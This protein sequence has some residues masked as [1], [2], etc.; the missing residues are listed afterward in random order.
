MARWEDMVTVGRVARTHGL[1]GHVIVDPLTDFVEERFAPGAVLEIET[2]GAVRPL[3]VA[4]SRLQVGRPVIS[5]EGLGRIE[6]VEALLGRELRVP[7]DALVPLEPGRYYRHDLVGCTVE[8]EDGRRIGDVTGV[9]G[10]TGGTHL[11]VRGD[12]GEVLIP[13]ARDVCPVIDVGARRIVVT[14][15]EGLL[16]AN[17]T[18][19]RTR[20]GRGGRRARQ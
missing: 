11:V 12:R 17:E 3:T 1:R 6:D 13:L 2:G 10:T 7:E 15:P 14:P 8:H 16:E 9:G 20:V 18:R 5:F 4:S 19:G